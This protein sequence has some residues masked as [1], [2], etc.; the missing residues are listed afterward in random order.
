MNQK[1]LEALSTFV[2][3]RDWDQ[4]HT[5]KNLTLALVG[6]VGELAEHFQWLTDQQILNLDSTKKEKVA[7]EIA[8]VFLYL[9]LLAKKLNLDLEEE[10]L[11]KISKNIEKYP[12]PLAKGNS[13]KYTEY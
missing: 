7:E 12:I 2:K 1:L 11:K 4:F 8:D 5:P 9:L 10:G 3:D 13:R 6:E